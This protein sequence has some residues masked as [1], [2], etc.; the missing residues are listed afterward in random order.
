MTTKLHHS[1]PCR[2]AAVLLLAGLGLAGCQGSPVV[3]LAPVPDPSQVLGP[4]G[5]QWV[6]AL[7]SGTA[8]PR[9][10]KDTGDHTFWLD[11]AQGGTFT[12]G[13]VTVAFPPG[14]VSGRARVTIHVPQSATVECDL[15]ISPAPLNQFSQPVRLTL[16]CQG[17]DVTPDNIAGLCIYWHEPKGGWVKV[18]DQVDPSTLSVSADLQHFSSYRSGW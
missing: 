18:G 1:L 7:R 2:M 12:Y 6:N 9:G 3:P 5:I 15:N 13:R 16:N 8:A 11:G 4:G 14:A 17:T 10:V